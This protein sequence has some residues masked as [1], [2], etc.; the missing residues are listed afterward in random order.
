MVLPGTMRVRVPARFAMLAALCLSV[1]AALAFV[2]L[3]CR[4]A[5]RSARRWRRCVVAG[6]LVDSW[7]GEM[8]LPEV[9][10]RLRRSNRCRNARR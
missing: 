1:V 5:G 6:V 2:R 8:P 7:I 9:P 10:V 3:T 4:A